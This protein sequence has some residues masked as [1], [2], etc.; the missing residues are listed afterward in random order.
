VRAGAE[1]ARPALWREA[2]AFLAELLSLL[3]AERRALAVVAATR[4]L[5]PPALPAAGDEALVRAEVLLDA[6]EHMLA[7]LIDI[8]AV[9]QR[10]VYRL[11][12]PADDQP[13]ELPADVVRRARAVLP[14][15]PLASPDAAPPG[16]EE[17]ARAVLA[18]AGVGDEGAAA[19]LAALGESELH[20]H[21]L[22][23]LGETVSLWPREPVGDLA[24]RRLAGELVAAIE[25]GDIGAAQRLAALVLA[26][27][28]AQARDTAV[29][30]GAAAA[31]RALRA[32]ERHAG[33]AIVAL[34]AALGEGAL[35][36]IIEAL[37]EEQNLAVRKRLIEAVA[38][39]G[40]AA[41]AHLLPCLEDPRWYV[42]RNAIFILRR[43]GCRAM[44]P[45]LKARLAGARPQVVAE[46]LKALVAFQDP[47]W[48]R[49]LQAELGGRDDERL[50]AVVGVASRIR[51]PA[52]VRALAELLQERLARR[53]RDDGV[54]VELICAL[55]RLRDAAALGAL[56]QVVE[57]R[58]WR[59]SPALAHLRREA[60]VSI[61][62]LD[63]GE[64]RRVAMAL[65]GDR[66]ADLAAAVRAALERPARAPEEG[67]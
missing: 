32:G 8:P 55:G 46:S 65:T 59:S 52:V 54:L 6:V 29:R 58:Q 20:A 2:R 27:P 60:A 24:A 19:L 51:H 1:D 21:L 4:H 15:L 57:L 44:L 23:V 9:V 35:P 12:A 28:S 63:S 7:N 18:G 30:E 34:L 43:L 45:T 13:V 25:V 33:A 47:E 41:V 61:A 48:L 3:D 49:I 36:E 26:A 66:D 11:A 16:D 42:V 40:D 53:Q 50:L 10:A 62:M 67:E 39:Q 31:I 56:R 5:A 37:A 22:R 38:R 64:A 17:A 14:Q